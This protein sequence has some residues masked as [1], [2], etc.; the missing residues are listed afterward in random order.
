MKPGDAARIFD[1][2]D[3]AILLPVAQKM[4]APKIALVMAAMDPDAAKRL[5]VNLATHLNAREEP[6][7]PSNTAAPA[8]AEPA[9]AVK[10]PDAAPAKGG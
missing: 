2:L 4:K 9:P 10:L 8:P 1:K 7:P 5:T 3:M 6:M